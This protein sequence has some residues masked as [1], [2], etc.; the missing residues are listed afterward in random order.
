M[1]VRLGYSFTGWNTESNGSGTSYSV[2]ANY[3]MD[4][5][6]TL[7]AT[8]EMGLSVVNIASVY[9]ANTNPLAITSVADL[10]YLAQQVNVGG[11]IAYIDS[12]YTDGSG[13]ITA[14]T[15][16]YK[17]T[18]DI[19]LN[20]GTFTEAGAY[21][22]AGSE[23]LQAWTPIGTS[24]HMFNGNFD[25][26]SH[27]VSGIYINQEASDYQGLFGYVGTNGVIKNVG[28]VNSYIYGMNHVGGVVGYNQGI[29]STCYN[30][31]SVGGV[32]NVGGVAGTVMKS[33]S[34][35]YNTGNVSGGNNIG[36]VVG[37][38]STGQPIENCYN[39]G[40]IIGLSRVGGVKGTGYSPIINSY[41]AGTIIATG[42]GGYAGGITALSYAI[43]NCYNTGSVTGT[44]KVG[45]IAGSNMVVGGTI[46]SSYNSGSVSGTT[47]V[48]GVV[49]DVDSG[50]TV[51]AS[52]N[53]GSVSG[54]SNVGGVVGLNNGTITSCYYDQQMCTVGG[55]NGL[56][57][58][59][60]AEGKLT[61]EMTGTQLQDG[62]VAN[63]WGVNNWIF[64]ES[65]YPRINGT[66][67]MLP[68]TDVAYISVAP[69]FLG[70][71]DVS[72]AVKTGFTLGTS[73]GVNWTS[74]N[75][76]VISVV[77]NNPSIVS[78]GTAVLTATVNGSVS[79]K[80]TIGVN[81]SAMVTV[82][83]DGSLWTP[84][85][86]T[87]TLKN[88]ATLAVNV[89]GARIPSGTYSILANGTDTGS[90]IIVDTSDV[91]E[92]LNYYSI[93]YT[94]SNVS[95]AFEP[96]DILGASDLT[97][98]VLQDVGYSLPSSI[99]V[100]MFGHDGG[101]TSVASAAEAYTAGEYY[102]NASTGVVKIAKVNGAV[103]ISVAAVSQTYNMTA[104]ALTVF[105]SQ[106][107]GYASAPV[108]QTVT[109]TNT[110]NQAITLTEPATTNASSNYDI[111][112]LSTTT[113]DVSGTATF[114]VQPKTGLTVGPYSETIN[115]AGTNSS[116]TS[117]AAQ[118]TV[119]AASSGNTSTSK[120][121]GGTSV[122][123]N[124]ETN[125][126]GYV[127][128]STEEG[129]MVTKVI[130]DEGKLES[131]LN[132][133]GE[134]ASVIISV[135]TGSDVAS[136]MLTGQMIKKMEKHQAALE[137]RTPS[138]TYKL[139]A[140]EI[141][142]D[143]ISEQFGTIVMLNDIKVTIEIEKTS[144]GTTVLLENSA[145]KGEFTI[146]APPVKFKVSC[147]YGEKTIDVSKFN[148]Y[149]ERRVA[150]AEGVD[151]GKITT[152][153]VVDADGTVRHVPTKIMIIDGKY[154]AKI[155][156]LTNSVYSVI[157]NP[158]EF[159][160]VVNHWAKDEIND[161]GSRMIVNGVG[162][163]TFSPQREITRAEFAAIVIRSLGLQP[164]TGDNNFLDV[165]QTDWYLPYI[166]TAYAYGIV[167]GYDKDHFGPMDQ[168][169]REEAMT[170]VARAMKITG[171]QVEFMANEAEE[172]LVAF[173]DAQQSSVWS[174]ESM[175]ICI[176][177]DIVSG[178][179]A[180][181]LAPQDKITRSE[182]AVIIR[183][184]L[185]KSNLI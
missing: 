105:D 35:S 83:K 66:K 135:T 70:S 170:M 141:N 23:S 107:V 73:N 109:I 180:S 175:A 176:K 102:Y 116:A 19:I 130:V 11:N 36:G 64:G 62:N 9:D 158:I 53:T 50:R 90:D 115:I 34:D 56:D 177:T 59:G 112:T 79:K 92:T 7:Y 67:N 31:G 80:V 32:T 96:V 91:I 183:R 182:V 14:T 140:S 153:V 45:G 86:P 155:N 160:D 24:T 126:V 134:H 30:T 165:N 18:G 104:S 173:K 100:T 77:G 101:M 29:T 58:I 85:E 48:G 98:S 131:I 123:V 8:W 120:N 157:W 156:S 5:S 124:D 28:T 16:S 10:A 60:Q 42:N 88:D 6:L 184:L 127:E 20:P 87:V 128:D 179:S 93:S 27:T 181:I 151:L 33:C 166:E 78:G 44:S 3:T 110:G 94:K 81:G 54:T 137:I 159:K 49:G 17:L 129:K 99:S 52:Y 22:Q 114:T 164:G 148:S 119:I 2:G 150:I 71:E 106:T 133:Q 12:S 46:T 74:G 185:Q 111:G 169:T 89:N 162:N 152:G 113:L 21:I 144:Q 61:I 142:I 65:I 125:S 95:Y 132:K 167:S 122:I 136:F 161:M 178:K 1:P 154:F 118:F 84:G 72:T 38:S 103:S 57:V 174:R 146:V 171:P 149:V 168:I 68:T 4:A 37:F 163:D 108:A 82:N 143:A 47:N 121:N 138:A 69:V 139:P 43:T 13:S 51:L 97:L 15:A 55:I 26:L 145:K 172:L 117:V 76:S 41:N 147:T 63:P 40:R 75:A 39:L 25:G